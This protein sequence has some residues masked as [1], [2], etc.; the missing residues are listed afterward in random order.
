MRE[1]VLRTGILLTG[2]LL[3]AG[4]LDAQDEAASLFS[5]ASDSRLW[6]SG[7]ANAIF[8]AHP[9]FHADYSGPHSLVASSEHATSA[10][11]TLYLGWQPSSRTE[12]I[13]D[14]ES[15]GGKGLSDALGLAGFTN[16]DVVRNP[17]LGATPYLA[18][19]QFAVT[20]P[21]SA[22]E[23]DASRSPLSLLVRR[24]V[25]GLSVRIG[26]LG[27]ADFFDLNTVGSDSHLQFTN[28]TVDNNGA[29]DYAADTRGYTVGAIVE[30]R[31]RSFSARYGLAL[32]PKVANGID[33]DADLLRARGENLELERRRGLLPGRDGVQRFLVYRNKANMGLYSEAIAAY[34]GGAT[35]TPDI[36]ASRAQGRVKWGAG[37]NLEQS[38]TART[39]AFLRAGWNS[40][41]TESF[42]YTECHSSLALGLDR[43]A[44][45][46][47]RPADRLGLAFVSNGLSDE[48]ARYLELGGL[49]FLLGDGGLRYGREEILETYYTARVFRGVFPA[50]GYQRIWRPGYNRDRGPV[51][52]FA[53]RVHVDL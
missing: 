9:D 35:A 45:L 49:G 42:A 3:C 27:V 34:E 48:H 40:G 32:M 17:T 10:L 30:Y 28:W 36:V 44:L 52:V 4:R 46:P 8:Q 15:A 43:L 11:L 24:P 53:L 19:F 37:L 22:E 31:D 25:K 5:H 7:Q 18:R 50:L 6:I 20:V 16:L 2:V 38:L 39:R 21:L 41:D 1:V 29:Y 26:K 14:V 51:S 47:G 12:L 33:L 13:L 23:E